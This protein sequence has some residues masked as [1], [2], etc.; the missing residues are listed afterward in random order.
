MG[1]TE[2]WV[3]YGL[4]AGMISYNLYYSAS[5]PSDTDSHVIVQF[6]LQAYMNSGA[7]F[8][9]DIVNTGLW[10][11]GSNYALGQLKGA[12]PS[13]G[14]GTISKTS[15]KIDVY[16]TN[17]YV[18]GIR[19]IMDSPLNRADGGTSG[20][21]DTYPDINISVPAYVS[22]TYTDQIDHWARWF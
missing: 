16:T 4:K 10:C 8:G 2:G 7:Y 9:Y 3:W 5:R 19:L 14:W 18:P 6:E 17:N 22:P 20:I 13:S 15:Q 1:Y 21:Y 12:T 11:N